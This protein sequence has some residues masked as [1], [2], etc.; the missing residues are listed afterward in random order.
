[1]FRRLAVALI[2]PLLLLLV[3]V[4]PAL[5]AT[6]SHVQLDGT[7][8]LVL[9]EDLD[10]GTATYQYHLRTDRETL[11]LTFAGDAPEGFVNGARVR[12]Q[13]HRFGA[14]TLAADGGTPGT[15]VLASAPTWNGP[16][17]LAVVMIN[18]SNNAT[19]PFTR[20]YVNGVIF[21]NP[22]SVRAY[23]AEE[24]GGA[25]QLAGTTFDWMKIPVSN[26]TCDFGAW[27]AAGKAGL[28]ARGVD[29][30]SYT[31]FMF[32]FPQSN[33]CAW[34]GLGYVPG[35]TT[36]LNGTPSLR[37]AAHELAHNFGV[38]HA[39]TLRCTSSGVRVALS[40]T[41]TRSEYGDPFTTMGAASTRHND[42]LARVQMG[43]LPASATR[44]ITANGT[45]TITKSFAFSGV[46]VLGIP[47]GDGS[48]FY[49][50][51]RRPYGTY[52]DNYS[53]TSGAVTG[54][55]V[56]LAKGWSTI[57]QSGLIDMV[58][59][60][61]TFADAPLKS[62]RTFKDYA[63]GI[64]ITV[65][66]LTTSTA[67]VVIKLPAD[68]VAPTTPGALHATAVTTTSV[69]MA[70]TAAT[71]NRA[72]A[73]YRI[74][75][76]GTT[77]AT[78][79]AASTSWTDAALVGAT[80][81]TWTVRAV[82]G[83]GNAGPAATMT[84][85][86]ATPDA[87]PTSVSNVTAT[88]SPTTARITWGAASDD[89]GV[90]GYRVWQDGAILGTISGTSLTIDSLTPGTSYTWTV[91]AVDSIGQ[92]GAAATVQASTTLPDT[93]APTSVQLTVASANHGWATISWTAA[94]DD[95]AVS[96]YRVYRDGALYA[97]VDATTTNL[98]V[99]TGSTYS[100]TA[101]DRAANESPH[102][103]EVKV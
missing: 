13:G 101:L 74:A 26:S 25:V 97:T 50:D 102:S 66:S 5:A 40:T 94:T 39:S 99:Q 14:A 51:Y 9:G 96:T 89:H 67:T 24:S 33:A 65:S 2:I 56:R 83:A 44:T 53:S 57:T 93:T 42:T 90:T 54:V 86:T 84:A 28:Q 91:R 80:S 95:V 4:P 77:V 88:M 27:E 37:T 72:V 29:L 55:A 3:V 52:F 32:V 8:E 46:R 11:R 73:S 69:A 60:T 68:T 16:R 6:A 21:A 43:Y 18:F 10:S 61:T 98:R 58:P 15:A 1:M 19:K 17:R 38:H 47:R 23:F 59:S 87:A 103:N 63:K 41:C 45:Y 62:G 76:G 79:P 82:D 12:V 35:P 30:A 75:R 31:N 64:T 49:L 92:L 34:R 36:W 7:L 48:W 22:N 78:V 81:Y 71:D 100:V 70:W 20:S 85:T